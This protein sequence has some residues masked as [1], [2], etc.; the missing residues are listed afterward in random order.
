MPKNIAIFSDGTGQ[1][2]GLPGAIPSNVYR[3]FMACPVTPGIQETYYEYG[4]GS[5]LDGSQLNHW[6]RLYNLASRCTG[7]G[8]TSNIADCYDAL[9]RMYEPGDRIFLFG[10]S[11]GAYAV[12]SL[13]GVLSLCGIPRYSPHGIDLRTDKRARKRAVNRA[14]RHVYE[15][16]G[17]SKIRKRE[18]HVRSER[19]RKQY[20]S[21]DAVPYF[22]GVWDTVRALG[23]PGVSSFVFWRHRFHDFGLD[24]RVS[25]ARHAL[26]IDENRLIFFPELW[27]E[28]ESDRASNRIK[29]VWFAGVH[30]DVGGGYQEFELSD[31]AL[32]WMIDEATAIAQPLIVEKPLLNP[33]HRGMQHDERRGW[34]RLWMKGTREA[35]RDKAVA[36]EGNVGKRLDEPSVPSVDGEMPYRPPLLAHYP[37]FLKYYHTM[38]AKRR[39]FLQRMRAFSST[40]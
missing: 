31:L 16:Y 12:R 37:E 32:E 36:F 5:P 38:E 22:I 39:G 40:K 35:F 7:L 17:R 26:S 19:F 9:I 13:G 20:R 30:S 24:E 23:L 10:F 33:S 14:V 29:Q 34:G 6:R 11:R 27:E 8:I 28:R 21:A 15:T 4:V 18:R 25:Y 3:L 2:G 1:A